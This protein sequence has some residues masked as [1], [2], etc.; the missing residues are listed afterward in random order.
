MT[1]ILVIEDE[2]AIR[3]NLLDLLAAED[4]DV[5]GAENGLAGLELARAEVPDLVL[6]DVMM[7]NLDGY[8]VLTM[9]RQDPLTAT[10]PFIFI[11]AKVDKIDV[12]QGMSL[13]ADDYLTKPFTQSDVLS[14]ISIRLAKQTANQQRLRQEMN[15]L[16]NSIALTLPHE[17]RT[18]LSGILGYGEFLKEAAQELEPQEI[19]EVAG[20]ICESAQRLQRLVKDFLLFADLQLIATDSN[21]MRAIRYQQTPAAKLVIQRSAVEVAER[22]NRSSDLEI[23]LQDARVQLSSSWLEKIVSEL[24]DNACKY[25]TKGTAIQVE[26]TVN[27]KTYRLRVIDRGRGMSARQIASIGAYVQFDR[28]RYEQQGAGLGLSIVSLMAQLCEGEITISS[29]PGQQTT[30]QISLPAP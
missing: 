3:E 23:V 17:L 5:F 2:E 10:I 12:R 30:V 7:P 6:C 1:R 11:T 19:E 20:F 26:A 21:R 29:V 15:Q 28:Q 13:G 25:S 18:P 27:A 8:G 22:Y 9:L 4:F 16:R 14:A 24:I